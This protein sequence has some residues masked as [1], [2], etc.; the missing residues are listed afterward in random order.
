[1]DDNKWIYEKTVRYF[2]QPVWEFMEDDSVSEILINGPSSIYIERKGRLV[3]SDRQFSDDSHLWAA[4]KNIAQF[5]NKR[6]DEFTNDLEARLPDGSRVHVVFPPASHHGLSVSI[7][8]FAKNT[9][10]LERLVE[11]GSLSPAAKEFLELVVA[12]K[13]N[14]I[15]SG[16]TG[17]GKT[18]LLNAVSRAIPSGERIIV[19]ED[20][21]ELQ[22]QQEHV[23]SLEARKPDR[24]GRGAATIRDLFRSSLRMRPDR[25]IIGEIRGGEG[26][27][28]LQAM[29]SGHSGSL[30]T[31]HAN[32]P[33]DALS[34]LE[35]LS[36]LSGV[37]M[38]LYALRSQIASAIDLI[39]QT[40]RMPDASRKI[41]YV[42][43]VLSLNSDGNYQTRDIFVFKYQGQEEGSA[44]KG[45]LSWTGAT[46]E[47]AP[48]LVSQGFL[49]RL[50]LTAEVFGA[51]SLR[52]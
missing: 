2:L 9:F 43:E 11:Y 3:L 39:I 6:I 33:K 25:I 38:P 50:N 28:M 34:R 4:V 36:L 22:L 8:K 49:S 26:L 30:S 46:P 45:E 42:T 32:S 48:E 27:D 31:L 5:S 18:S 20:S 51:A 23:L 12:F 41:T 24:K 13:K 1:M 19:I 44:S 17:S 10:T 15:V 40:S 16:G 7:R 37:E 29:N 47:F 35:T 21:S 52:G 14:I